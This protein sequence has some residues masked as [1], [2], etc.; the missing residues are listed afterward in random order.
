MQIYPKTIVSMVV[1]IILYSANPAKAELLPYGGFAL[2]PVKSSKS[3]QYELS[4]GLHLFFGIQTQYNVTYEA[5]LTLIGTQTTTDNSEENIVS[6]LSLTALGH[7]P[8]GDSSIFV[9]YGFSHWYEGLD[10]AGSDK[11]GISPTVGAGIDF[12]VKPRLTI[13]L[14][15]QRY[16]EIGIIQKDFD[17]DHTRIGLM[18]YF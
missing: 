16:M 11:N 4:N 10:H 3:D 5:S 13:R 2:G 9:R 15:W 1:T 6:L 18:Y 14:E 17:I 12:G 8:I 7:I